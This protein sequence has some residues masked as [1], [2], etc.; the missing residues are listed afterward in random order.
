MSR[1]EALLR[2]LEANEHLPMLAQ[3]VSAGGLKLTMDCFRSQKDPYGRAWKPLA[4]E[5]TRDKRARLRVEAKGKKSRG[6]KILIDTARMRNSS[7]S[8]QQGNAGGVA[9]STGYAAAHQGGARI[10][11]EPTLREQAARSMAGRTARQAST[12]ILP[13][14]MMLPDAAM[15]LPAPWRFMIQAE[16]AGLMRRIQREVVA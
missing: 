2:R 11:R 10:R 6:G 5:R 1:A 4:R 8:I 15:G 14:R 12:T 7:H 16:G 3:L 9:I 13:Q